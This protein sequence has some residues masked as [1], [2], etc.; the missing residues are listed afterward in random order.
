MRNKL[1]NL[2]RVLKNQIVY[3]NNK[4]VSRSLTYNFKMIFLSR[5]TINSA[6]QLMSLF[7]PIFLFQFFGLK[8]Y[9]V[10]IYYLI[11]DFLFLSLMAKGCS[12]FINKYGINKS[13]QISIIFGSLHYASLFLIDYFLL[14]NISIFSIANIWWLLPTI[15]LS[16][17]FRLS[18]WIPYHTCISK[19]TEQNIRR[20]Q[21]SLL[22]ATIL[23]TGVIMP[24]I[25]GII[26]KYF[27]FSWLFIVALVI[28]L[29]SLI[30]F[31][32]L[33][34]VREKFTWTYKE[35]W[36]K[37]FSKKMR[38]NLLAYIG[39]GAES[40]IKIIIWP[41]FIWI[42]LDGSYFQVG[43]ISAVVI[44]ISIIIQ[45]ILG[46]VLDNSKHKNAWL[47]YSSI[48]L[49]IA[50]IL[51][52]SIINIW[53]IFIYSTLYNTIR[54]F[55]RTSLLPTH[56]DIASDQGEYG[57]EYNLIREKGFMIGR[58]V[59]HSLSL[60]IILYYP[61]NYIFYLAALF[62]ILFIFLRRGILIN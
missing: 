40:G 36:Q 3:L 56:Y 12:Y 16:T 19:L 35:T 33:P 59:A 46:N 55:T 58:V 26:L 49:A 47:S 21:F 37:A 53:Q 18:H 22:E 5:I 32:K 24:I 44:F 50:W 54:I 30:F 27:S 1:L 4:Y 2:L 60:V 28:Y 48:L 8:I 42:I 52:A 6:T 38:F 11:N 9:W 51:K 13:L 10:L 25:A 43:Y 62:S 15:F 7:L 45:M 29:L 41:I 57:D 20:S 34:K 31:S 14:A 17:L 39:E 61:L 23:S